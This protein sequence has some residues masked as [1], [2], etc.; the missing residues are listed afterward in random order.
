MA[1]YE[2]CNAKGRQA[3][4]NKR[5]WR[6][7]LFSWMNGTM[8]VFTTLAWPQFVQACLPSDTDLNLRCMELWWILWN[9][10]G[11]SMKFSQ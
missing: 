8:N 2:E 4:S 1:E 5:K 7:C 9:L 11:N 6:E 3:K 10:Y